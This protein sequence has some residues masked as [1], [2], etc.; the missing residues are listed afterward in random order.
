MTP[1][2]YKVV[3]DY[4]GEGF[5]ESFANMV[6]DFVDRREELELDWK[7]LQAAI[8]DK[9]DELMAI[10]DKLWK[11]RTVDVRLQP[12]VDAVLDLIGKP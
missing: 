1:R 4:R 5:N 3:E 2:I 7:R 9:H 11:V 8:N 12:L 6:S 10:Q